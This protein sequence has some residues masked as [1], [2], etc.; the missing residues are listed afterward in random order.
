MGEKKGEATLGC[1]PKNKG[2]I[3]CYFT[4]V[5]LVPIL[6]ADSGQA[7]TQTLQP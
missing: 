4:T 1:S 6:S 3:S 7:W 5:R 2:D